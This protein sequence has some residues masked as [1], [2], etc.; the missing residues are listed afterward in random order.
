MNRRM[1]IATMFVVLAL[2][3]LLPV[4]M[5]SAMQAEGAQT[6]SALNAPGAV[7]S[8]ATSG[9]ALPLPSPAPA[10]QVA[11]LGAMSGEFADMHLA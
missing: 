1:I 6:L 4:E 5:S 3:C 7:V 11:G 8:D 9:A 10:P 2:F